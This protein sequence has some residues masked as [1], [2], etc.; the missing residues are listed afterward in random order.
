MSLKFLAF[1]SHVYEDETIAVNLKNY[2]EQIFL[3]CK[4]F[5]S[6]KDLR[7]GEV[8]INEIKEKL[9]KSTVIISIISDFSFNSNW[10]LFESGAG[11]IANK[12][13]PFCITP[14]KVSSLKPPFSLLHSRNFDNS[15]LIELIKDI[16]KK[17]QQRIPTHI[18]DIE[19]EIKKL[20]EF[21]DLRNSGEKNNPKEQINQISTISTNSLFPERDKEIIERYQQVEKKFK[22]ILLQR[23][24]EVDKNT[25]DIPTQDEM[26]NMPLRE[27]LSISKFTK[28]TYDL[29]L[30]M[31]LNMI[32]L[33]LLTPND[34]KWE[35]MNTLKSIESV[36]N[37][38]AKN[39]IRIPI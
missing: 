32:G 34:T 1:I 2:L 13:I 17:N 39:L 16:A 31:D 30:A 27:I 38:M 18:P 12:T 28:V 29:N 8:W 26:M 23:L 37:D 35:K 15:G 5:V 4:V 20:N 22:Q 36:E 6:G 11:F 10:V 19:N 33:R 7:G 21:L 25:Y 14:I 9:D 3:N 24:K